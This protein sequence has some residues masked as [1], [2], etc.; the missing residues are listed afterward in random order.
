LTNLYKRARG[1]LSK[2]YINLVN[3]IG[4]IDDDEMFLDDGK[5]IKLDDFT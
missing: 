4:E 1:N 2:Q 3:E 5:E